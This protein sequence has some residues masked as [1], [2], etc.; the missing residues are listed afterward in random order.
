MIQSKQEI[1]QLPSEQVAF[2]C[3]KLRSRKFAVHPSV[4][5]RR[6]F[7]LVCTNKRGKSSNNRLDQRNQK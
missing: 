4:D 3:N 5:L 1:E 6:P 2:S 7:S